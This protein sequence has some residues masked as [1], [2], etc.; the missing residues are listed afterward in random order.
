M[1]A[2][3]RAPRTR[4]RAAATIPSCAKYA[5]DG[6]F[7]SSASTPP[8]TVNVAPEASKVQIAYEL[9]DPDH[10]RADEPQ[11]ATTAV[12][13]SLVPPARECDEPRRRRLPDNAPGDTGCPTG[14][15]R[16]ANGQLSN[17]LDGG[18]FPLNAQGYAEDLAIDLP[19]RRAH[20]CRDVR[21]GQQLHRTC[22][23]G[24]GHGND[25]TQLRR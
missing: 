1:Q 16:F 22:S 14:N 10:G 24:H 9:F 18:T 3:L 11:C 17:L 13:G 5:G 2:P 7:G 20:H 25:H 8:V 19:G 4:C 6:T 21:R 12:F 15:I 23:A